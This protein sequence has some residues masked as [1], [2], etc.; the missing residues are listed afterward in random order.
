MKIRTIFIIVALSLGL[1]NFQS[2]ARVTVNQLDCVASQLL[3]ASRVPNLSGRIVAHA[4]KSYG[5]AAIDWR[6]TFA[7]IYVHPERML[8]E[9]LNT[10]AF[11]I[12]H[13]LAHHILGHR[14][15]HGPP[16][17][18]AADILGAEMA[19]RAGYNVKEYIREIYSNPNSCALSHGCWYDRARNLER[20]FGYVPERNPF[21]SLPSPGRRVPCRHRIPCQHRVP[22]QH[23]IPCQHLVWTAYGW[24]RLHAYDLA[25]PYDLLHQYDYLHQYDIVK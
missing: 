20:R 13:E 18:F 1:V 24:Q 6:G 22:C 10:W 12:G 8:N 7:T 3:Q 2:L 11:V 14:G 5:F 25:H 19:I 23:R 16:Q 15:S 21:L 4:T 17:E 9:T